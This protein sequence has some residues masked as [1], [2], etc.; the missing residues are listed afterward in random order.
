MCAVDS[1]SMQGHARTSEQEDWFVGVGGGE[2]AGV[3]SA[4]AMAWRPGQ[5][6]LS[7]GGGTSL[8]G[9]CTN[10]A[11]VIDWS[12]YCHR[13]IHVDPDHRRCV[14]EPG[15]VLD[16]LNRRLARYGLRYGPEPAVLRWL[17]TS[18][19]RLVR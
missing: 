3:V 10:R 19:R 18:G 6:G 4:Q 11:V 13:L 5:A 14:V 17:I 16:E 7:R 8:S 12:E 15:I 2:G 1:A 9:Q